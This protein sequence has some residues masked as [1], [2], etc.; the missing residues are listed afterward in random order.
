MSTQNFPD[1]ILY[2][3]DNLEVLRGMNSDTVDLIATDPPFNTRRNRA[4]TAGFYVDNWRWGDTGILPDQWKWNEVHPIWLDQI[5]DENRALFEVVEATAHS[6]GEDIAAFIC[7]LSVRLLECHRVLKPTGSIYLHC[8]HAANAYIRMAM[9]AIFG[10]RNF[11]SEIVWRK[12]A[13]RKNNATTKFSTQHDTIFFYGKSRE[14]A[15]NVQYEPISQEEIKKK[16]KFTDENGRVYRE[17]WGRHYQMTGENRRIYLDEQPGSA[18]GTLW[19]ED[20]LQLNTSSAERTGAPDQKP[21]SLYERIILA[22]SNAGDLVLDPFA[23]C[24]TTIMAARKHKRRWVGIDRRKDGRFHIVCRMMGIKAADA[25]KLAER[26][27]LAD[28][29]TGQLAQYEA[30]FS[31]DAPIRTD[32]GA[33]AGPDL[34]PVYVT[35]ERSKLSHAEMHAILWEKFGPQCWACDFV[36]PWPEYLE[37]DHANPKSDGGSNHLDNRAL[38]CR[39]CN[40]KKGNRKTLSALRRDNRKDGR[41]TGPDPVDLRYAASWARGE[42]ARRGA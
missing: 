3:M 39:P 10:A 18:I 37:L 23:G 41:L 28:W 36:A 19:V 21:L 13:G 22:S 24:A 2:E 26:P 15:F 8:D 27:D 38:L 29:L 16:Y 31:T 5:K 30:H 25:K 33:I 42:L 35:D 40:G 1:N 17:A 12:Y 4:G 14:A 9:D 7:F 32:G 34:P 11:R 6:H 20:G